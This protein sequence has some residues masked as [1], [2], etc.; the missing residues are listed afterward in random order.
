MPYLSYD[1]PNYNETKCRQI[2]LEVEQLTRIVYCA[3]LDT[4]Y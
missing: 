2:H 3:K 4:V 1:Q